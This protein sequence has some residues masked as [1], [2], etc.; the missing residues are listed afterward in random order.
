MISLRFSIH[1]MTKRS[2]ATSFVYVYT[3]DV[4]F[5]L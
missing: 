2:Q 3:R 1:I 5:K 4:W